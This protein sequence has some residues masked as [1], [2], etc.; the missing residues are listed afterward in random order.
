MV[1]IA[2]IQRRQR[3]IASWMSV[4]TTTRPL[5]TLI[6]QNASSNADSKF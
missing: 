5:E 6:D 3:K 1:V 4:E 2:Q